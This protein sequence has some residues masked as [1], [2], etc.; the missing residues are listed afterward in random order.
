MKY[1]VESDW[2]PTTYW[3]GNVKLATFRDP[4]IGPLEAEVTVEN[5][6]RWVE[7]NKEAQR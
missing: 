4:R 1:I 6:E 7:F 5:L 3:V 2:P